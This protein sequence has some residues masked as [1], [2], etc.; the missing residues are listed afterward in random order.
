MNFPSKIT[1]IYRGWQRPLLWTL[2]YERVNTVDFFF[3]QTPDG[4]VAAGVSSVSGSR[5]D[6]PMRWWEELFLDVW[7]PS[8]R[9][10]AFLK[11]GVPPNS[12]MVYKGIFQSKMDDD[13]GYPYF[14]KSPYHD[15]TMYSTWITRGTHCWVRWIWY[16]KIHTPQQ[17]FTNAFRF[18]LPTQVSTDTIQGCTHVKRAPVHGCAHPFRTKIGARLNSCK[19]RIGVCQH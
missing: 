7:L 18:Y 14:R 6:R 11:G 19:R 9:Y 10:G 8:S 3:D 17:W 5:F 4:S 15:N 2:D 16:G 13:W 1:F 12:W